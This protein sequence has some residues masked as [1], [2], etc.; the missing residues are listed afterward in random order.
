MLAD[1][2]RKKIEAMLQEQTIP[3]SASR[4]AREFSVSRQV[5]VGDIALIRAAGTDIEATPR[6]YLLKR[7]DNSGF[8]GTIACKHSKE[9]MHDELYIIV[10]LGGK[11]LDVIVD[12]PIYGQL[13]GQ[14]QLSS[15]YDV[16]QFLRKIEKEHA[17]PLSRIT[18]GVHL[19]TVQCPDKSTYNRIIE[20]LRDQGILYY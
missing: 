6:G 10:D 20:A 8:T 4:L 7:F 14:L 17:E 16:D 12:H 19:H 18:D 13:T 2:R 11:I 9:A 5:I 15:R 1:T 3:L